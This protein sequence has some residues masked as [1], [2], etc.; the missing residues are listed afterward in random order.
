M[1]ININI[2]KEEDGIIKNIHGVGH[3]ITTLL[4]KRACKTGLK[5]NINITKEEDGIMNHIHGIGHHI[6]IIRWDIIRVLQLQQM[7]EVTTK[8][9]GMK[10]KK[11]MIQ[12]VIKDQK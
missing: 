9:H 11:T 6:T 4:T 10:G 8:I 12:Q 7:G 1:K 5:I 3:R 2:S